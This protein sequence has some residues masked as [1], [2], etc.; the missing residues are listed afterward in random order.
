MAQNGNSGQS[1]LQRGPVSNYINTV[2]Q[3]AYNGQVG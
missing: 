3:T 2:G 1:I